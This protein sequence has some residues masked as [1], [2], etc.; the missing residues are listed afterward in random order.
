[1]KHVFIVNPISGKGAAKAAVPFI[2]KICKERN[3]NFDIILTQ[4]PKHAQEIASLYTLK[5]E[6]CLYSVG[7]DGTAYEILNGINDKVCLSIIPCGTG[8]DFYRCIGTPSASL[9]QQILD[10]LDG[11]IVEVDYGVSNHTRFLN[12]TTLGFDAE[13]NH[14]VNT[15]M[16]KTFLPA[17]AMYFTAA[18]QQLINPPCHHAKI[19]IDDQLIEQDILLVAV[20]NGKYYGGGFNPTPNA[21]IQ[22]GCFDLCIIEPLSRKRII[23]LLSKYMK[24]Q[25]TSLR[26]CKMVKGRHIQIKLEQEVSMQSDG[27]N[28]QDNTIRFDLMHGA[29]VLKVPQHSPLK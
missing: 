26:E 13:I 10:A 4:Y 21:N 29:L 1:M 27:E 18:L 22:D 7:G 2:E 14:L 5:E 15:K 17:K 6:V 24:G 9:E 3:Y 11:R 8:N 19:Q 23:A 16:K 25:H 12:C 28:F 20:M